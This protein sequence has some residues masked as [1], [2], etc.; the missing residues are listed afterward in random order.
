MPSN[1][2]EGYPRI[3][4][5]LFYEDADAA[6]EFLV[7]AFG[8]K[9]RMR[10]SDGDGRVTHAE[11]ELADGVVMLGTPPDF[12]RSRDTG[13]V[14]VYVDDVD[15]HCAHAREAG[16]EIARELADQDY[17]DR[18][19]GAKDP[20]G[21]SWWFAQHVRDVSPEELSATTA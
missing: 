19:Y 17:G 1:P 7:R 3:C 15:A 16:A 5:Y 6:I 8:F 9:E 12:E 14:H 21:H 20:E 13:L 2:P 10:M 4:P 11:L 18:N